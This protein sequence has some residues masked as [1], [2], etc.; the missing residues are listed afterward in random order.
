MKQKQKQ[1]HIKLTRFGRK[2]QAKGLVPFLFGK[3]VVWATDL[4]NAKA[5][6]TE[7]LQKRL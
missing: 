3:E 1:K 6:Y 5:K 7:R 2:L 4:D